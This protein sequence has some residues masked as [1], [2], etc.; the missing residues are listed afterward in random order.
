MQPP[1]RGV[2]GDMASYLQQEFL[3]LEGNEWW[4]HIS[5]SRQYTKS[6][7]TASDVV[8][9]ALHLL[10]L[11]RMKNTFGR[12]IFAFQKRFYDSIGNGKLGKSSRQACLY[13]TLGFLS[14]TPLF[15][16]VIGGYILMNTESRT[17][18]LISCPAGGRLG[19]LFGYRSVCVVAQFLLPFC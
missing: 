8:P 11:C 12:L 17:T 6:H 3:F 5:L 19:S 14:S 9:E 18:R 4:H 7:G 16:K 15:Q 13:S 10:H 2:I 1:Q